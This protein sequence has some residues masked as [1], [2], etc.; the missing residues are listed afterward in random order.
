MNITSSPTQRTAFVVLGMHRSGTSALTR[1]I[2]LLGADISSN[3]MPA[4]EVNERGFWES[5]DIYELHSAMFADVNRAWDS[6]NA[7][8]AEWLRSSPAIEYKSRFIALIQ[9]E[10][11][12]SSSIVL[13]DPRICI[14]VPFWDTLLREA[15]FSPHYIIPFRNPSEVA[16]SIYRHHSRNPLWSYLLWLRHVLEAELAT[17]EM[18]RCFISYDM[19]LE[20]WNEVVVKIFRDLELPLPDISETVRIEIDTFLS[21]SLRH[22]VESIDEFEQRVDVSRWVK[23]VYRTTF[24]L[25]NADSPSVRAVFDTVRQEFEEACFA[26]EPLLTEQ[27]RTLQETIDR[28]QVI[29]KAIVAERDASREAHLQAE[30][31][32]VEI[33]A[34]KDST[35]QLLE[36]ANTYRAELETKLYELQIQL[37]HANGVIEEADKHIDGLTNALEAMRTSTSWKITRP[38]RTLTGLFK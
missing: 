28:F 26:F 36:Q 23:D 31:R 37:D 2:N 24:D 6:L 21:P 32:V 15:G 34:L 10:F 7:F 29:E 11:A 22:H 30:Q 3:L 18:K 25:I 19:L 35:Q 1:V 27:Q 20:N 38:F 12:N 33:S 13:K 8:P 9:R 5:Q 16:S 4:Q 14:L 17:R